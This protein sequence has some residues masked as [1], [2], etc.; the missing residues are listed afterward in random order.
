VLAPQK[1][2]AAGTA[3][4]YYGAATP[5]VVAATIGYLGFTIVS[6]CYGLL[7][8]T[9]AILCGSLPWI[10]LYHRRYRSLSAIAALTVLALPPL[11]FVTVGYPLI[12]TGRCFPGLGWIGLAIPIGALLCFRNGLRSFVAMSSLILTLG[13]HAFFVRPR[14]NPNI[15]TIKT[16]F[17]DPRSQSGPSL[18]K[19]TNFVF[20]AGLAHPGQVLLFPETTLPMWSSD[21]DRYWEPTL[22]QLAQQRT[23]LILGTSLPIPRTNA[24]RNVLITR[25]YGLHGAYVQRIAVPFLMWEPGSRS[26]GYPL[27]LKAFPYMDVRGKRAAVLLCFEQL[28]AWPAFESFA[29]NPQMLLAPSN[30]YW[31]WR[32][33]V[34]AIQHAAVQNWADLF[35]IPLYEVHNR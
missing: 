19:R 8:W 13:A 20:E 11:S 3:I 21:T 27:Q 7:F 23:S 18:L 16:A 30:Q 29:K 9:L 12:A 17:G 26:I 35:R 10:V 22:H 1:R 24:N 2:Y 15:L 4:A 32:T 5:S 14:P 28:L 33:N 31:A 6:L 25:G 34:P